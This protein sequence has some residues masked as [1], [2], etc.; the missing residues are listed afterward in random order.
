MR[1]RVVATRPVSVKRPR[2]GGR[3]IRTRSYCTWA[4]FMAQAL[5][6]TPPFWLATAHVLIDPEY[7]KSSTKQAVYRGSFLDFYHGGR[8]DTGNVRYRLRRRR[9]WA[10]RVWRREGNRVGAV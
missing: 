4:R 6:P 9:R 2:D 10:R 5:F 8:S 3:S 1:A 7:S